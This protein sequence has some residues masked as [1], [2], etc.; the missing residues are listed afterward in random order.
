[1]KSMSEHASKRTLKNDALFVAA[2]VVLGVTRRLPRPL[3]RALG[4]IT[5]ALAYALVPSARRIALSNRARVAPQELL[6]A[7]RS[8]VW[9]VYQSL[10]RALGDTVSLLGK[11]NTLSRKRPS[12]FD[13]VPWGAGGRDALD[14]AIARGRGVVF[15]SAHLGPWEH[16]AGTLVHHGIPLTALAR[17]SYDPRFTKLYDAI[18]GGLGVPV[19]YR[20]ER[21]AAHRM[22]R[23]LRA[24]GVLGIPMDL[25]SRVPSVR[26]PF[27]G[28][29]AD[30][31][32]GPARLALRTKSSVVVGTLAPDPNGG[33]PVLTTT[34]IPTDDL[35]DTFGTRG[36]AEHDRVVEL[37]RRIND[38]LSRRILAL[39]HLW[40][41][42]H[43]R[44]EGSDA[45][46]SSTP[47]KASGSPQGMGQS[48]GTQR[49]T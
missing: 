34:A 41:W 33:A 2:S 31:P 38:E 49:F 39:P 22:L 44:F 14:A 7:R 17:E 48:W 28:I 37:T 13:P 35:H 3:L 45:F 32:S 20:G 27:L 46:G 36:T 47:Q 26:V 25:R 9:R 23:T 42:M 19:V 8:F 21:Y 40:V 30:T 6:A 24:G 43:P 29:D 11:P 18:R 15:A 16:V 1:M 10:G 5:A 4:R 12:A